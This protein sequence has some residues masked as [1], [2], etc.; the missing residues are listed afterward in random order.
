MLAMMFGPEAVASFA[1]LDSMCNGGE[2]DTGPGDGVCNMG[3]FMAMTADPALDP[4]LCGDDIVCTCNNAVVQEMLDCQDDP[5][6]AES[7]DSIAPMEALCAGI[8]TGGD[9]GS[10]GD[11]VCQISQVVAFS[12]DPAMDPDTCGGDLMCLCNNA[13][14]K[15]MMDCRD[16]P[17]AAIFLEGA[18]DEM[19]DLST[20]C[21]AIT[22]PGGVEG[23]AGDHVCSELS[24][25][26]LC[27]DGTLDMASS[28][29][30]SGTEMCSHPCAQE[31][32]DCV[33]SPLL[34]E[35]RDMIVGLQQVCSGEQAECL[36]IVA[37]MGDYFDEACCSGA[38]LEP[39]TDGPPATCTTG[40]SAMYLPF[41]R[42]CGSVVNGLGQG[43]DDFAQIATAMENFNTICTTAHPGKT[44]PGKGGGH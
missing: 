9:A 26:M 6:F 43:S 36:P 27:D 3:G 4:D 34:A 24:A 38:G 39:C 29:E 14:I 15:E 5:I 22:G 41:W 7:A 2:G 19:A 25:S 44:R 8:N 42:D 13:V 10:P 28:G 11:G 21:M 16:D 40:C 12:Q 35:N 32:M 31:M 17:S 20:S 18:E 30:M 23:S 37:N 1:Q 33:D